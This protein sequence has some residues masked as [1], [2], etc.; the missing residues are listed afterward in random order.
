MANQ[1]RENNPNW[2]GGRS[3]ASNGYILIRV[4]IEH[5]DA[6]VRG[7]AYEHRLVAQKKIGRRLRDG[8]LVHHKDENKQNN[9]PDN[10]DVKQGNAEHLLEHRKEGSNRRLPGEDNS[11]ILCACECGQKFAKYDSMGRP[12]EYVTG[13]NPYSSPTQEKILLLIGNG[14]AN[15]KEI[16]SNSGLTGTAIAVAL[17]KM[18]KAGKIVSIGFGVYAIKKEDACE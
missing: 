15:R 11:M 14:L 10:L 7:Y 2:R 16:I 12:R 18:K 8:E 3:L 1:E 6:D 4:G 17:T 5:L 9:N 13:H